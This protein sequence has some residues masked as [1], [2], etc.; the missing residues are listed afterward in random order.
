MF[1]AETLG[2]PVRRLNRS[3]VVPIGSTEVVFSPDPLATPYHFAINIPSFHEKEALQWLQHRVELLPF[4]GQALV[5]FPA[6]SAKAMYFYD[7]A[8]NIVELIARRNLGLRAPLPFSAKSL[9]EVSEIG[10]APD[11]IEETY[12]TLHKNCAMEIFDGN[13]DTFCAIGDEYG[14]FIAV[15]KQRKLWMPTDDEVFSSPFAVVMMTAGGK[16]WHVEY[17]GAHIA[18]NSA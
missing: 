9:L 12:H 16:I 5:D 14:L 2:L 18:C 15:D 11:S 7:P 1:Y 3:V 4:Q 13:L 6:W 8:G 17:D 10:M